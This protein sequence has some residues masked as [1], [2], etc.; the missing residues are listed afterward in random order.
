MMPQRMFALFAIFILF[1]IS[2][3]SFYTVNEG[4]Q[5]ILLR[6]GNIVKE[7]NQI[8]LV[9]PGLHSKLPFLDEVHRFDTRLQTFSSLSTRILTKEQKYVLVDYFVKW[10]IANIPLYY[11]RTDGYALQTERL[12]EQKINDVLRTALG[13]YSITDAVTGERGNIMLLLKAQADSSAKSLGI[14]VIDVRIK[15]IDLPKEVSSSVYSRMQTE[16]QQV[17]MKHRSNGKSVAETIQATAD[18]KAAI[19][20][21]RSQLDAAR[22]RAQ[23][24]TEAAAIYNKAYTQ[25]PD[26]YALYRSLE[27]YRNSFNSKNDFLLLKPDSEFFKYF[28]N[29]EVK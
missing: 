18:A 22:I 5:A 9:L 17:A 8:K 12:L 25:N 14:E 29:I 1:I 19:L 24:A 16:R 13:K 15:R 3:A 27:A 7:D 21:A 6:L 11:T 26:F 23:G 20:L 28:G 2:Y 4:Q 10:R